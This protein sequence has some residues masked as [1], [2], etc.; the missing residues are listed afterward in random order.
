MKVEELASWWE[1]GFSFL[2]G[3]PCRA[4]SLGAGLPGPQTGAAGTAED[5][6]AGYPWALHCQGSLCMMV[7]LPAQ[8]RALPGPAAPW[9]G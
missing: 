7:A 1:W 5:R 2:V 8:V 4:Q 3:L 9:D 6:G